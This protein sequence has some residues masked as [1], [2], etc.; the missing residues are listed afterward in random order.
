MI[1][2][3]RNYYNVNPIPFGMFGVNSSCTRYATKDFLFPFQLKRTAEGDA[4]IKAELI[5][6][7][8]EDV[9][10]I[11]LD[12]GLTATATTI[13]FPARFILTGVKTGGCSRLRITDNGVEFLSAPFQL[14]D[15]VP[16]NYIKLTWGNSTSGAPLFL[17]SWTLDFSDGFEFFTYIDTNIAGGDF[18][19]Q[20]DVTDRDGEIF[21]LKLLSTSK[22]KTADITTDRAMLE[23]LR[24]V[25]LCDDIRLQTE[26]VEFIIQD[27]LFT[28]KWLNTG[29]LAATSCEFSVGNAITRVGFDYKQ[30]DRGDFNNDF[31]NDFYVQ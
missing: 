31:N 2:I 12:A 17:N 19:V 1:R 8:V 24:L 3:D 28:P 22:Y 4:T 30:L 16:A 27:I 7:S 9:T 15:V 11:M 23:A 29:V 20:E 6:A 5:G 21:P 18:S 25:N 14:V 26:N 13:K 10:D